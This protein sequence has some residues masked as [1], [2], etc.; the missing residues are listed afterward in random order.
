MSETS[1][2]KPRNFL[3]LRGTA[4]IEIGLFHSLAVGIDYHFFDG[5]R[6]WQV[7][8]HPFWVIVLLI[9]IQYGTREGLVAA[10]AASTALLAGNLPEQAFS[11]DVYD[12]LLR[13]TGQPLMWFSAA[14]VIGELRMR[15]VHEREELRTNLSEAEQREQ[16]IANAYRRLQSAKESLETRVAG[17]LRTTASMYQAARTMGHLDPGEALRGGAAMVRSAMNP[18]QFSLFLLNGDLLEASMTEGW[19]KDDSFSRSFTRQSPL[20]RE[21]IGNR[22]MLSRAN[23]ED[24]PVLG[25]EGFFAGP[26]T[27][28]ESGEVLGMLKIERLEFLDFN[29]SSVESFKILCAWIGTAVANGRR[30]QMA[31]S[32]SIDDNQQSLPLYNGFFRRQMEMLTGLAKRIGFDVFMIVVRLVNAR[33]L[34]EEKQNLIHATMA[35]AAKDALAGTDLGFS[36]EHTR[37]ESTIVLPGTC[38]ENA[39]IVADKVKASLSQQLKDR[40]NGARFSL[41]IQ[42]IYRSDQGE[43]SALAERH[44]T[45]STAL[46]GAAK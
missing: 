18:Q 13:I 25:D 29:L 19:N 8:P 3:G 28:M 15:Q 34:T 11:Q 46:S 21:V 26:L 40:A 43:G 24:G 32:G 22:R 31:R 20:F 23:P 39:Q 4:L 2:K 30:Y 33:S 17:Q 10:G 36:Y 1:Q 41:A 12:Y 16:A 45:S 42:P 14:V 9:S 37:C 5:S 38:L 44:V 7:R 35:R 27:D 6:Y